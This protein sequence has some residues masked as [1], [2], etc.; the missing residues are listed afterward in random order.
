MWNVVKRNQT[1]LLL[2]AVLYTLYIWSILNKI[3]G[4]I[5]VELV[6]KHICNKIFA[7]E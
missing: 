7:S 6:L 3:K 1:T 5:K 2:V 4:E